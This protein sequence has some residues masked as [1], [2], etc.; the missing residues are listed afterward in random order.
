MIFMDGMTIDEMTTY[1]L[2][3]YWYIGIIAGIVIMIYEEI[4]DRIEK[5]RSNSNEK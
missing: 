4:V 5:K 1:L 3:N 2:K